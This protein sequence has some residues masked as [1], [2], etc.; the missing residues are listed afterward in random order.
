MQRQRSRAQRA[1]YAKRQRDV[2]LAPSRVFLASV[3]LS[4]AQRDQG[5]VNVL[6]L[7][8][9][10]T[11]QLRHPGVRWWWGARQALEGFGAYCYLCDRIVTTWARNW[12]MTGAAK[13]AVLAH[14]DTAHVGG[15]LNQ[16]SEPAAD[17]AGAD[18]SEG[19]SR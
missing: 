12:P 10:P 4:A 5:E 13:Q 16:G 1:A 8:L 19:S 3:N 18:Q 2:R 9:V 11:A 6:D 15:A 17:L 7:A 14:R